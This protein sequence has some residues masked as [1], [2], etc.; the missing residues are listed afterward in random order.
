MICI[1]QQTTNGCRSSFTRSDPLLGHVYVDRHLSGKNED[2]SS[3]VML[4]GAA[5]TG[6]CGHHRRRSHRHRK[7]RGKKL[8][9]HNGKIQSAQTECAPPRRSPRRRESLKSVNS[10]SCLATQRFFNDRNV[11]ILN[12]PSDMEKPTWDRRSAMV[13][14]D[15]MSLPELAGLIS[16]QLDDAIE[17]GLYPTLKHSNLSQ[18]GS[19][20]SI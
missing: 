5:D 12:E 7:R 1:N 13:D 20:A 11:D 18:R 15:Q 2:S 8:K 6:D 3:P 4:S 17:R 10:D 16:R 14:D 19:S 9:S